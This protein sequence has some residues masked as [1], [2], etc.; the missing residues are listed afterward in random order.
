VFI[1]AALTLALTLSLSQDAAPSPSGAFKIVLQFPATDDRPAF[2][3]PVSRDVV[4]SVRRAVDA[5]GHHMGWDLAANDRRLE[6]DTNFFYE[7]LCGHGPRPHDLYAWHFATNHYPGDRLLPV[8]G[9]PWDVRVRC[10]GCEV[11]GTDG[12]NAR[13]V[14]GSIE[15]SVR[16]LS[17]ANQRQRRISDVIAR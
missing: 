17:H 14:R 8:Y 11:E 1:A 16:R 4:L 10:I 7:C 2:S 13:F 5:R 9:Y 6:R 3:V 12:T 15:V